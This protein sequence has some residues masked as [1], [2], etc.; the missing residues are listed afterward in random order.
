VQTTYIPKGQ[1][2]KLRLGYSQQRL[3]AKTA[4]ETQKMTSMAAV[5]VWDQKTRDLMTTV[6]VTLHEIGGAMLVDAR[7]ER[8]CRIET[9]RL[10]VNASHH[11]EVCPKANCDIKLFSRPKSTIALCVVQSCLERLVCSADGKDGKDGCVPMIHQIAPDCSQHT[12][13]KLLDITKQLTLKVTGAM[14]RAQVSAA[15]DI[16][17]RWDQHSA[18]IPCGSDVGSATPSVVLN[19][20]TSDDPGDDIKSLSAE[21]GQERDDKFQDD[22][23]LYG[24]RD[25]VLAASRIANVS[26]DVR[27]VALSA[28]QEKAVSAW[29]IEYNTLPRDV[30]GVVL[31]RAAAAKL[32]KVDC[33]TLLMEQVCSEYEISPTTAIDASAH[34]LDRMTSECAETTVAFGDGIF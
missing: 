20:F 26:N 30:I 17:I 5:P 3:Q 29:L 12:L 24:A 18:C 19:A 7:I 33:T 16:A 1:Q 23:P 10:I 9:R 11:A 32:R 13:F 15:V 14:Q 4:S 2:K 31:L 34:I 28:I 8:Y 22:D 21:L 27:G 25:M 6:M